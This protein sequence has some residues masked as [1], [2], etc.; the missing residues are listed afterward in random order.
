MG[1]LWNV[2]SWVAGVGVWITRGLLMFMVLAYLAEAS[3]W[4][5]VLLTA[6]GGGYLVR[7]WLIDRE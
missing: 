1:H 4:L 7:D 3:V 2:V 6:G 5:V